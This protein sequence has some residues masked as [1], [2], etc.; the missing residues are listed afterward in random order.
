MVSSGIDMG[1]DLTINANATLDTTGSNYPLTVAGS[2]QV[3]GILTCNASAVSL[4]SGITS[5]WGLEVVSGGTFNGG[6]GDHTYGCV[7][8]KT[9]STATSTSGDVI[10]NSNGGGGIAYTVALHAGCTWENSESEWTITGATANTYFKGANSTGLYDVI[11]NNGSATWT[12]V[13]YMYVENNMTITAGTV[14]TGS[15]YALTVAGKTTITGTLTCNDS[16]CYF[17][18]G[19]TSDYGIVMVAAGTF[20]G[21]SG[22][23]TTGAIRCTTDSTFDFTSGTTNIN[24]GYASG[25]RFFEL[26]DG[27]ITHS[28]GT[29]LLNAATTEDIQWATTEGDNG[30]WNLTIN[31]ANCRTGGRTDITILNDL[32]ITAGEYNTQSTS[33]S[34]KPNLT[35]TGDV[36]VTGTLTGNDSAI[37]MGSLT[38]PSGGTYSATS[39]TTTITSEGDGSSGTNG[40]ALIAGSGATLTHNGG[41][42]S[43][44]TDATTV[45]YVQSATNTFNDLI[46]N[47]DG[48][49][50]QWDGSLT[51]LGDLTINA[52]DTF[53][54]DGANNG[55]TVDGDV[56][57]SGTLGYAS[58]AWAG[59]ASYGSLTIA[60]GGTY[61]AT[62]GT[63]T[64]TGG[65]R[66][67]DVAGTL[68]LNG[69]AWA[70]GGTGGNFEG[71]FLKTEREVR[72]NQ[73]KVLNFDGAS[74]KVDLN[75]GNAVNTQA[76]MTFS[77]WVN[78]DDEAATSDEI[79]LGANNGTNQRF[80]LA[81]YN[82]NFSFGYGSEAWV[83]SSPNNVIAGEW[84]HICLTTTSGAQVLY[85]NGVSSQS[86]SVSSTF[87][88]ASDIYV[89]QQGTSTDYG[90]DGKISDVRIYDSVLG[91]ADIA[92]LSSKMFVGVGAPVGWWKLNEETATGGGAGTGFI[93]DSGSGGNEGIITGTSWTYDDFS[94][95]IQDATTT[96][97]NLIVESGQLNTKA[98]T[99]VDFDGI[100]DYI[101]TADN[102][103]LN[104]GGSDFTIAAWVNKTG[105][106]AEAIF[107]NGSLGQSGG[108]FLLAGNGSSQD[109]VLQVE[110]SGSTWKKANSSTV[111][112]S[113]WNHVVGTCDV[114]SATGL[115][116]YINGVETAYTMQNDPTSITIASGSGYTQR[117]GS[118]HAGSH[119]WTGNIRDVRLY[120]LSLSS[121]QVASLYRGSYNVTPKHGWKLDEGHATA[122][123]NNAVGAFEDFGTGTDADGQGVSL[124][125][126]SGINGSLKV[127]GA[128]RVLTNGSVL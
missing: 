46:I 16:D 109:L 85:V 80:Y 26:S 9:G 124:V 105:N 18:A 118:S 88:L 35:V 22:T 82:E 56:S 93:Q 3:A 63:T 94:V 12:S 6:T 83:D 128:A 68:T 33:V 44:D 91:A 97:S 99:S 107:S 53:Q 25:N 42:F 38:I 49:R 110:D 86:K 112:A 28:S 64:I 14:N 60:S 1:G 43:I 55:L 96:V 61:M 32:T 21:G 81:V 20:A 89:A 62:S 66:P 121:D 50:T 71:D 10:V 11:F 127:N 113:G 8:F 79:F 58:M 4:G 87:T 70:F 5:G 39:G 74:N 92:K 90:F 120:D 37:S 117:I 102:A 76:G 57:V 77:C 54:A 29:I 106:T 98:L 95:D 17:G 100:A 34:A 23:H 27:V 116:L 48:N 69:G 47:N 2:T 36:S 73:D 103:S 114:D 72:I 126:A 108:F 41:T 52:S 19:V 104:L 122:A 45:I 7:Y 59:A 111:L 84:A 31:H 123:L 75:Y 125:D 115:K 101:T 51:I 65:F 15:N 13:A 30:P 24:A 119:Y 40:Y 78:M 67:A